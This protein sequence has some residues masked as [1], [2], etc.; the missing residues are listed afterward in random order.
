[1]KAVEVPNV[2][3]G[4]FAE[5]ISITAMTT[6]VG[7]V[8][9]AVV[10]CTNAFMSSLFGS[11]AKEELGPRRGVPIVPPRNPS[12]RSSTHGVP[13]TSLGLYSGET[14]T[15]GDNK[16]VPS[17][18]INDDFADCT[19]GSDEPGTSA[20][21][22]GFVC[23]NEGHRPVVITS[24]RVNDGICDC[25][26]GSDEGYRVECSN[27][28]D[29]DAQ[30]EF[31]AK[32][33]LIDTFERGSAS[34]KA[35]RDKAKERYDTEV[36][37]IAAMEEELNRLILAKQDIQEAVDLAEEERKNSI[38]GLTTVATEKTSEM[39]HLNDMKDEVVEELVL[40]MLDALEMPIADK[41]DLVADYLMSKG[42]EV[43]RSLGTGGRKLRR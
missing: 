25:C 31:L 14:F 30:A 10:V 33:G 7:I 37:R 1:M 21:G 43:K 6:Q 26:D 28:C 16:V 20:G 8:V 15:C 23:L 27:T 32:K 39:L 24:S 38:E 17:S 2:I 29:Q 36:T 12:P 19:D 22:G 4:H 18:A 34:R 42:V 40:A 9:L 41:E 3:E 5:R 13:E 11:G 35:L